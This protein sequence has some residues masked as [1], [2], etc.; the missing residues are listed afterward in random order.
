MLN[1]H[2]E[3][4]VPVEVV[5]L[6][7][8]RVEAV[9]HHVGIQLS[10]DSQLVG[11]LIVCAYAEAKSREHGRFRPELFEGTAG[12]AIDIGYL[13][14]L[15]GIVV[16]EPTAQ[17]ETGKEVGPEVAH[18]VLAH[19]EGGEVQVTLDGRHEVVPLV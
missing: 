9:A 18:R 5:V 7:L 11:D 16:V 1:F 13:G 14:C 3:I 17:S 10:A 6:A 4:E 19:E 12:D 2:E 8:L 15:D